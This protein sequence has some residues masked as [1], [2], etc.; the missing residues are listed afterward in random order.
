MNKLIS[1]LLPMALIFLAW[2]CQKD[3]FT[4]VRSNDDPVQVTYRAKPGGETA[5]N[6][7]S[8]PVIWAEGETLSLREVDP[9]VPEDEPYVL[10][11]EFWYYWDAGDGTVETCPSD[12]E[13]PDLCEDGS[14]PGPGALKA[15]VQKDPDNQWQAQNDIATQQPVYVDSIDWGDN[16]ES[17]AWYTKSQVRAEVV[18]YKMLSGSDPYY[19]IMR[20]YEMQFLYGLGIDEVHGVATDETG[21]PYNSIDH[22]N[23]GLGTQATV[24]SPCSRFMIQKLMLPRESMD[25]DQLEFIPSVGWTEIDPTLNLIN[26]PIFNMAVHEAEDGPGYYNAEVNVKGKVIYGYTWNVR[27]LNDPTGIDGLVDPVA[28]DY[29]LTFSFDEGCPTVALNTSL[30]HAGIIR[31][32]EEE[33]EAAILAEEDDGGSSE[34]GYPQMYDYD[35]GTLTYVDVRILDSKSGSNKGGGKGG[36]NSGNNDN[37]GGKGGGK[38]N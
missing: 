8:F 34:G 15:Y 28:G 9:T 7:L 25:N 36:G 37:G 23:R 19:P 5:G 32:S 20:E 21:K 22:P 24:F 31:P 30:E 4:K 33:E 38:N 2:N 29:R 11:G 1:V 6:N 17:V 26:D 12:P 35:E 10:Q 3:E 18:L 13:N 27:K 16:L 14:T